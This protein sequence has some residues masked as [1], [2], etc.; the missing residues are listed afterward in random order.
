M[1]TR[2]WEER[3]QR[4][5]ECSAFREFRGVSQ[6][7]VQSGAEGGVGQW[8]MMF[9]NAEAGSE[10]VRGEMQ[11]WGMC[12]VFMYLFSTALENRITNSYLVHL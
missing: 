7:V 10:W 9:P 12:T 11:L 1:S 4:W 8:R 2:Q 5:L 3:G 6:S